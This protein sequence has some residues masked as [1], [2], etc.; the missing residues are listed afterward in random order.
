MIVT[1]K[2]RRNSLKESRPTKAMYNVML[3]PC[4]SFMQIN[5]LETGPFVLAT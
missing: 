5:Q 2:G 4:A 1:T 3:L